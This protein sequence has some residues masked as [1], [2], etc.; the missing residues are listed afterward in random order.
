MKKVLNTGSQEIFEWSLIHKTRLNLHSLLQ[1]PLEQVSL[2]LSFSGL[3][4]FT[5]REVLL[6]FLSFYNIAGLKST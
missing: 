3:C 1:S 2:S 4:F 6:S 5:Y